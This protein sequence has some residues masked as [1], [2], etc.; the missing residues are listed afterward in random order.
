MG[1]NERPRIGF[2]G[3]GVMGQPMARN[4][5]QAGYACTV[6]DVN[7][8]PVA[9]LVAEGARSAEDVRTV[10]AASDILI[11]MVVDDAQFSAI[12]FEP[13]QAA[14]ALCEGAIVM[15]MSTMSVSMVQSAAARLGER[16][17]S[18]VDAPVSG[19]EVGAIN[20]ALS[21]MVGGPSEVVERCQP[22]LQTL[23]SNVYHVGQ[24]AGDGQ[25]VKMINQLM[26]C[27]HNA[28]AAE[29]LVFGER[30]GLDRAMLYE[31][32]TKSAGN[33]W[34][35]SDRGQRMVS[36]QFTPPKSAL[37]ILVKDL[38]F[39]M[40][41]ANDMGHPLLL[42]GVAHQLYKMAHAK[43]WDNL[44]DSILVRLMEEITSKS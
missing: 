15:G 42:G 9:A 2:I 19:G 10:A 41:T 25:A 34:I 22:V 8:A 3:V 36:E 32:I 33:S 23:G 14:Q 30:A 26:V 28:I 43:G 24:K 13:G 1:E 18:Y 27:V 20:G 29:A 6:Y 5:L 38:G 17:I 31:I 39:V 16:G 12:L 44:D 40:E 35:F 21:I 7:P 37:K 4:L 11:T